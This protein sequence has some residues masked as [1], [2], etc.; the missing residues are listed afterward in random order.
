[1]LFP[2]IDRRKAQPSPRPSGPLRLSEDDRLILR[3]LA[4][5]LRT[6]AD[7]LTALS[8]NRSD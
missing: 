4:A 3:L 5:T 1:M 7:K 8:E 6:C 2:R